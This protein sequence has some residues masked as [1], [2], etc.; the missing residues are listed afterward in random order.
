MEAYSRPTAIV[1]AQREYNFYNETDLTVNASYSSLNGGN[2]LTV[3]Y[4][5]KETSATTW[6]AYATMQNNVP[7]VLNLDNG[8]TWN[9]QVLLTDSLGGTTTINTPVIPKGIPLAMF[10]FLRNSVGFNCIPQ[11]DDS[12][13]VGGDIYEGG[14]ALEAKYAPKLSVLANESTLG[15]TGGTTVATGGDW[16]TLGSYTFQPGQ[17]IIFTRLRVNGNT[18]GTRRMMWSNSTS[19]IDAWRENAYEVVRGCAG[20]TNLQ[21][22]FFA[23][24][25]T[26]ET[27]YLRFYQDSGSALAAYVS[28]Q[29]IK[30]G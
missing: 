24:T 26:S 3:Q 11:H 30:I 28:V 15:W 6:S 4:R 20:W 23:A 9:V 2:Q 29:I 5:Y 13:E 10:D 8:T 17:Y 1:N 12:L 16:K 25:S 21:C 18:N 27:K 14:T 19:S 22:V 7:A